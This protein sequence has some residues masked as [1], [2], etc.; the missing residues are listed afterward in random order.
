MLGQE[1]GE[2]GAPSFVQKVGEVG[3]ARPHPAQVW[4]T[5]VSF[6]E[7]IVCQANLIGLVP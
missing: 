5:V 3:G 2:E 4:G 6:Q 1:R 7:D